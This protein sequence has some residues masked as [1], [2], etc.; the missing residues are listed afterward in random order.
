MAG[1]CQRAARGR[2]VRQIDGTLEA[3]VK[4]GTITLPRV[5]S[6][7]WPSRWPISWI[8]VVQSMYQSSDMLADVG[9][10]QR[11]RATTQFV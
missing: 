5:G 7:G 1:P 10:R 11:A 4:T 6:W 8:I 9:Q 3:S 2:V